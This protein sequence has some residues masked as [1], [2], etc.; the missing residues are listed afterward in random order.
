MVINKY[1]IADPTQRYHITCGDKHAFQINAY[2]I[3]QLMSKAS[4]SLSLSLSNLVVILKHEYI[5]Q[6]IYLNVVLFFINILDSYNCIFIFKDK[7][8]K[9]S[10]FQLFGSNLLLIFMVYGFTCL[11]NRWRQLISDVCFL[12]E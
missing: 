12:I 3:G 5:T 1:A 2:N 7:K 6:Y 9:N 4:D 8:E 11:D 10:F